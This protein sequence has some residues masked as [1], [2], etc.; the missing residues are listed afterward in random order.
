MHVDVEHGLPG[1]LAAVHHD[2]VA[3]L[4]KTLAARVP[5]RGQCQLSDQHMHRRLRRDVLE[6]Q[7]LVILVDDGGRDL[8][9]DDLAEEGFGAH[10]RPRRG[11]R[12]HCRPAAPGHAQRLLNRGTRCAFR[13]RATAC[14]GQHTQARRRAAA[15][16]PG[17]WAAPSARAP[18]APGSARWPLPR[19]SRWWR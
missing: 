14:H 12:P 17:G 5:G 15:L 9:P 11:Y 4:G 6:A 2:A 13:T 7:H 10:G 8:A 1:M 18:A 3:V 19:R 16:A